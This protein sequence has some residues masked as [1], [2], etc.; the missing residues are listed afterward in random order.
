MEWNDMARAMQRA[1]ASGSEEYL[2]DLLR[3]C[4]GTVWQERGPWFVT[5]FVG[6]LIGY[7]ICYFII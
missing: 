4:A 1:G 2:E 3:R 5:T 7:A 6:G